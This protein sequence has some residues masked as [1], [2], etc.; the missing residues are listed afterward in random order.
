MKNMIRDHE[1]YLISMEKGG[2]RNPSSKLDKDKEV[3]LREQQNLLKQIA[4][5]I[6]QK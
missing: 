5:I 4:H 2:S 3:A 6:A 1:R